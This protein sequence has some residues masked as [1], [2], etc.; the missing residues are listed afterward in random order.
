MKYFIGL[1]STLHDPSLAIIDS[2]GQVV[3]AESTER[4]LQQKRGIGSQADTYQ[5]LQSLLLKY[6]NP[7]AEF[8]IATSWSKWHLRKLQIIDVIGVSKLISKNRNLSFLSEADHCWNLKLQLASNLTAGRSLEQVLRS[9]F[10]N[11][12]IKWHRFDHHTCHAAFASYSSGF[13]NA[14]CLVVDGTG[15]AGSVSAF[16]FQNKKLKRFFEHHGTESLGGFYILLT[17]FCGFNPMLGEEWKTMGLAS[18]G[19]KHEVVYSQLKSLLRVNG[20]NLCWNKSSTV[21]EIKKTIKEILQKESDS[22]QIKADVAFTGQLVFSELMLEVLNNLHNK[23]K[24]QNIIL[25]GGVALNSSFN[26]TILSK[27]EFQQLYVPSAPADDGNAIGAAWLAFQK[28]MKTNPSQLKVPFSPF[29]GS[30]I[31]EEDIK[32]FI[33]YSGLKN[34]HNTPEQTIF[35]TAKFLA[36]GKIVAWVQGKA[37]FGPRALGNR[38]ILADP[39]SKKVRNKLNENV[40]FR[41]QFR[42]FAP[43]ILPEFGEIYFEN[44]QDSPYM[45]RTLRFRKEVIN[46]IPGVVHVDQTGRLQTVFQSVNPKFYSLISAFHQITD[47]P[48]LLN[49]SFN[50]M[51]KPIVHSFSD[52]LTVFLG[53]DIEVMVVNDYIFEK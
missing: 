45:E 48:I 12:N 36:E 23:E 4:Y 32:R 29:L 42:P 33:C 9:N 51:G 7:N 46:Q 15:E 14:V 39:R 28:T 18:Y 34:S 52:A 5:R 50:V 26:G 41:E 37:E 22:F 40:K 31:D 35:K 3:F 13:N 25:T 30:E 24:K 1:N 43:S 20:L 11:S 44:Y 53:S 27:T 2:E 19:K 17:E 49:T 38:S 10:A 21:W 8:H 16:T 47:I 6:C